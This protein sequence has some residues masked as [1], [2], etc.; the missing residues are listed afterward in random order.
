MDLFD[1]NQFIIDNYFTNLRRKNDTRPFLHK[2]ISFFLVDKFY[3]DL[4]NQ[5]KEKDPD[6]DVD[7]KKL[8]KIVID[9]Y[10]TI[11]NRGDIIEKINNNKI[12]LIDFTDLSKK[13][14]LLKVIQ[15]QQK[16][17]NTLFK[18]KTKQDLLKEKLFENSSIFHP[19][20]LGKK[21]E[22]KVKELKDK[23]EA[24]ELQNIPKK[25][26]RGRTNDRKRR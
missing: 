12:D 26:I 19:T 4:Y 17:E 21:E 18:T 23:K 11:K 5:L 10:N 1:K 9:V 8:E 24:D 3:I 6:E 2:I 14:E 16:F 7:K 25:K 22:G 20:Q 13:K 15:L